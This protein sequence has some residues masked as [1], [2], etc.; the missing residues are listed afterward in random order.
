MFIPG[1]GN[2]SAATKRYFPSRVYSSGCHQGAQAG[3]HPITVFAG[4]LA[5]QLPVYCRWGLVVLTGRLSRSR[6]NDRSLIITA[7]TVRARVA[8]DTVRRKPAL[9]ACLL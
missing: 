7:R 1:G 6:A 2:C 8:V 3:P 9:A 5:Y 4:L